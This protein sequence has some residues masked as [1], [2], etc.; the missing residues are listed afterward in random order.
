VLR[1]DEFRIAETTDM[2]EHESPLRLYF[3]ASLQTKQMH[4]SFIRFL[5]EFRRSL[6]SKTTCTAY[7]HVHK[8]LRLVGDSDNVLQFACEIVRKN[9][10]YSHRNRL[11]VESSA[12]QCFM[13]EFGDFC[14]RKK[15]EGLAPNIGHY[16][17]CFL[18]K[19]GLV[20][21]VI[22]TNWDDFIESCLSRDEFLETRVEVIANWQTILQKHISKASTGYL[23][24]IHGSVGPL[25]EFVLF[26]GIGDYLRSKKEKQR[27][28]R[29]AIE[30]ISRDKHTAVAVLGFSGNYD[31]HIMKLL[32]TCNR[33]RTTFVLI[34]PS[35]RRI[36]VDQLQNHI[37]VPLPASVGLVCLLFRLLERH[38]RNFREQKRRLLEGILF[39]SWKDDLL[40][41]IDDLIAVSQTQQGFNALSRS[42]DSDAE[43]SFLRCLFRLQNLR[44]TI[45]PS[46]K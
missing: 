30:M 10:E 27:L 24:K 31:E 35:R 28:V 8:I 29:K 38:T 41:E 32:H 37:L 11:K 5:R 22:S 15:R 26:T 18:L 45:E 13:N 12:L 46:H 33:A 3:P 44:E 14:D 21:T 20:K 34:N 9:H 43:V 16:L 40:S 19:L 23:F 6:A 42:A 4:A 25:E 17:V 1:Q 2:I 36:E 39:S 7:E